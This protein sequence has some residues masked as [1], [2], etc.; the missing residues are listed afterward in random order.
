VG[1]SISRRNGVVTVLT[2]SISEQG[3]G[4]GGGELWRPCRGT[5]TS[6][7]R[8][9]VGDCGVMRAYLRS[10]ADKCQ[11]GRSLVAIINPSCETR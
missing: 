2:V 8:A 1:T 9:G 11:Y 3:I 6:G 10:L 4:L 5:G 7:A